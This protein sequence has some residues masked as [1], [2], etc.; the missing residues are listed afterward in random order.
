MS[1][2]FFSFFKNQSVGLFC[3]AELLSSKET[4]A[5]VLASV[6]IIFVCCAPRAT[7]RICADLNISSDTSAMSSPGNQGALNMWS[8]PQWL[9]KVPTTLWALPYSLRFL[10]SPGTQV[11]HSHEYPVPCQF[12]PPD[13]HVSTLLVAVFVYNL[14]Q[15]L[16]MSK[17]V[18]SPYQLIIGCCCRFVGEREMYSSFFFSSSLADTLSPAGLQ[19]GF[20]LGSSWCFITTGLVSAVWSH[21]TLQRC[22]RGSPLQQSWVMGIHVLQVGPPYPSNFSRVSSAVFSLALPWGCTLSTF[23]KLSSPSLDQ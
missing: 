18:P 23:F 5:W 11:S 3:S 6:G 15:L 1:S 22:C 17:M 4:I 2:L 19:A 13:S 21:L 14:A 8:H 7:P 10:Y 20:P 12:S 9:P 16:R